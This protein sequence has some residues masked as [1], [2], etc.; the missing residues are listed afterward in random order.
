MV[1][2]DSEFLERYPPQLSGGQQQRVV[3]AMAL[4]KKPKLLLLDEPTTALDPKLKESVLALLQNL[5]DELGFLI[6]FVTHDIPSAEA[7]C[8]EIAILKDGRIIETG[9]MQEIIQNPKEDYTKML[10]Q[11]NFALRKFRQ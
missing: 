1:G 2:L 8:R 7:L 6:L 5:Q 9:P 4:A 11:S 3:I 10:I